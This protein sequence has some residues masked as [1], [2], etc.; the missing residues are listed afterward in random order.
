MLDGVGTIDAL[1]KRAKEL[2]QPAIAL[3]DHGN[4]FGSLEFYSKAKKT[5]IKPIVGYEAYVA[6]RHIKDN[7]ETQKETSHLTL[8]AMNH[9]GYK[10]LLKLASIAYTEGFRYKPRIDHSLLEKYNDGLICLSGCV[11]GRLAQLVLN[12]PSEECA[13]AAE[14]AQWYR[15]TFGDRYYI[16]L[17]D[18]GLEI[19]KT[20]LVG[21]LKVARQLGIPVAATNDV[22]YV[23]HEDA[24]SQ[25]FL[26][27]IRRQVL[28]SDAKRQRMDSD[29]F[30]LKTVEE[31]KLAMQSAPD[32]IETTVQIAER[33]D[34][35]IE[36]GKRFFPTFIPPDN[37]DPNDYLRELCIAGL[38]HRYADNPKRM[39]NGELT[40]EVMARLDR[41]IS[42]IKKLGFATYF[43]IVWDFV[44][45]AEEN[46]IHR[47]AR[48]SGVGALVCYALNMSHVCPLEFDLLFER[49][50]DEN[51]KEAPD[52]DIDFDQDRRIEIL[53]YVK[54]K[55]S[56]TNVAQLGVFGTMAA[57]NSIRDIGRVLN[58]TV[59]DVN[60]ITKLIPSVPHIK[61]DD[62]L[63]ESEE[64]RKRYENEPAIKELIDLAKKIEGLARNAGVHACGVIIADKP[65]T[66][67][68]PLTIDKKEGIITQWQGCDVE[69][70]GLLKMDFLG[71][72]NLSIL[73]HAIQ[74]VKETTGE[75]I[76][77]YRF[78]LDDKETYNLLCRGET[79]GVFQLES[80]GIRQLL[81]QMK[82]N[83]FRD[84]IA[85][86]ALYR[87]GPLNGG[88]VDQYV[89]VKHGRKQAQYDHD[90]MR[91]VLGETNGVMVYQEQI[92][93]ILNRL[94][95]IPLG[96]AYGCIKAIS[97]KKDFSKY[98]EQFIAGAKEN[99]LAE[100]KSNAIFE[101]IIQFAG[102]GF[103]KSHSTAYAFIAYMT[104]YLKTHYSIEFMAAL[105]CGD[106]SGRNF[107]GRD[108]TVEHYDDCKRMGIEIV[109]P[110]INRS[111]V[112]YKVEKQK[113]ENG[114]IVFALS[115]LKGCGDIA[116]GEIIKQRDK[117]GNFKDLFDFCERVDPK[118]CSPSVCEALIKSGAMDSF[119]V[120]RSQ[121]MQ[122][123][124]AAF[125]AGLAAADDKK[126]GQGNLFGAFGDTVSDE[127]NK[128]KNQL[129][130]TLQNIPEWSEKE[131]SA[132]EKS[133]LGFYLTSHPLQE[134]ES[135]FK[136]FRTHL[137]TD[138]VFLPDKA[139]VVIAGMISEVKIASIRNPKPGQLSQYVNLT[140][141]DISGSMRS[142][143]WPE[144][145]MKYQTLFRNDAILFAIGKIDKSRSQE[146][147]DGN[148]NL[149]VNELLTIAEARR[150]FMKELIVVID[151]KRHND[152][153]L[154]SLNEILRGS[155]GDINLLLHIRLT[156]GRVAELTSN[157]SIDVN[158]KLQDQITQL[159][160]E[161]SM[162]I[163]KR[164]QTNE[165]QNNY[166]KMS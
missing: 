149:I 138:A 130:K 39:V 19:Q 110:D 15:E 127:K 82:P 42:V 49:F 140:I 96:D 155:P 157:R 151:E 122:S 99:G 50:L 111:N 31:M 12:D 134:Y 152:S 74:L 46:G 68:V 27:C 146:D 71:L 132:N 133:I 153:T 87:P 83:N 79:K 9:A 10:N 124:E 137:I 44:R 115:A 91:D 32:A 160:G 1:L 147:G 159:L 106:I 65:L 158:D 30:Y 97:K 33:C 45:F 162:R 125:K 13:K 55:Y 113:G 92:M 109:P 77:P 4:M 64:L 40:D 116:S 5:G 154:K 107:S 63:E 141:E 143:A 139:N 148:V 57:K 56:E 128:A 104:A 112:K 119:G 51:R 6:L 118:I 22:H 7:T 105:L 88:M 67:Y 93:R 163:K 70:A 53:N 81:Q 54:E 136:P 102:Y 80:A 90:V 131:R 165:R 84:I 94:G 98:R 2:E 16:E 61:I 18:A 8:L 3:T 14:L 164:P 73:A 69:Q 86:N 142:I 103:N 161:N 66:E 58:F 100:D 89:D 17:Q 29:Q 145:Y 85:T 47:T 52:I 24:E 25:D 150:K 156:D 35:N 117:G 41:E 60:N 37:K 144:Q 38:K 26:S 78:P 126:H 123:L 75:T 166:A 20:A 59:A 135:I 101:L 36:T 34:L 48:G 43:L 21:C 23:M 121:L 120:P 108:A 62:A 114:K 11:K 129:P 28:R 95:K 72:R 76:D